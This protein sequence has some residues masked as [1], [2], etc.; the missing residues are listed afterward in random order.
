[1]NVGHNIRT[2]R[3]IKN[4]TQEFVAEKSG[5][6]AKWLG[7]I[8]NG[9]EPVS[10]E[11]INSIAKTLDVKT[12][13]LLNFNDKLVFNQSNTN[14]NNT[15]LINP[16]N[17]KWTSNYDSVEKIEALYEKLIAEKD[18]VIAEKNKQIEAL[19]AQLKKK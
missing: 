4:L 12:E 9:L 19:E 6:S 7:K 16:V 13:D 14:N 11:L 1:M 8:E 2:I 10:E 3:L 17:N 5:I 18:K 15:N